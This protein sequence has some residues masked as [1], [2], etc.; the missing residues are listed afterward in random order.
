VVADGLPGRLHLQMTMSRRVLPFALLLACL[1]SPL[2]SADHPQVVVLVRH[3]EKG[4]MP[5][6]D[7]T[8]NDTGQARAEEL[9]MALAEARID[10]IVV[11][12]FR[13][14]RDTAAPLSHALKLTPVVVE[15][16]TDTAQHARQVAAAVRRGGHAVLVV[17]H[18]NTVPAIIAALGGPAMQEL[19]ETAYANLFT[20]T[21]APGQ[22]ARLVHGHYGAPD[23]PSAAD[24]HRQMKQ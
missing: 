12:Q 11:T 23:P 3:A 22:P 15:A 21:L 10:T 2:R 4:T 1:P 5:A 24:C 6:G 17:G 19:C 9:A 13:R 8:L 18:S 14:T 7:V 20:M 16:G